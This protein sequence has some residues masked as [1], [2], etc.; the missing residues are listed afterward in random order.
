[1]SYFFLTI[2]IR[3]PTKYLSTPVIIKVH[4]D[5]GQG[6]TVRIQETLKQQIVLDRVDF[7]NSQTIGH[8]RTGS[9]TTSRTDRHT[10]FLTCRIN[11]VLYNQEVSWETHRFHDIQFEVHSLFDFFRQRFT[12]N[13]LSSVKS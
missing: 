6:D 7:R 11:K 2:F 8:R 5:I 1:M 10:Q 4:I 9:R 13:S 3:Y 12:I